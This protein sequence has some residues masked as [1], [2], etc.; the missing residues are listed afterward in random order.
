MMRIQNLISLLLAAFLVVP[1]RP[2]EALQVGR[3]NLSACEPVAGAPPH[4]FCGQLERPLDPANPTGEQ[5]SIHFEYYRHTAPGRSFGVMVAVEGGPGYPSTGTRDDYYVLY[6]PMRD[7]ND[8]LLMDSRGTGRSGA[9]RCEALQDA[10]TPTV[11]LV[12]ACG[13]QLGARAPLF[14]TSLAA[15]DLAAILD[16]LAL[17]RADLYADSYGTYFA[18]VFATRHGGKL[19]S[20]ILDGAYP[21]GGPD[22]AWYPNYAPAVRTRFNVACARSPAC[23]RLPGDSIGHIRPA[24]AL[25]RQHPHQVT[26]ID[27]DGQSHTFEANAARL[28]TLMFSGAPAYATLRETDA[29]ARAYASGDEAPLLRLMAESISATDSRDASN[30]PKNWSAGL[31]A[32]VMCLD[33]P[34]VFDLNLALPLRREQFRKVLAERARTQPLA[35]APFTQEEYL[36]LPLDYSFIEQCID[37]PAPPPAFPAPRVN[38][39]V[40][41]P[42][43]PA[44]VISGEF[45]TM[46][47]V[48]DAMAVAAHFRHSEHVILANSFHV[49]ALPHGRTDCAM[50]IAQRFLKTRQAGDTRCAQAVPPIALARDFARSVRTV[51]PAH[52]KAAGATDERALRCAAAAVLTAGDVL[53]RVRANGSGH[54]VGLRGGTF[55][56]SGPPQEQQVDLDAVRWTLDLSVS[57]QIQWRGDRAPVIAQLHWSESGPCG[58]GDLEVR[59][60]QDVADAQATVSGHIDAARVDAVLPAP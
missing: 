27:A 25:L 33:P 10:S 48:A 42:D 37:W 16:A 51:E 54:G 53:T 30:D 38:A 41:Y 3:L 34:Q 5:I 15:D 32:A 19:R 58:H 55:R 4:R 49:N 17:P 44:L 60:P 36:G 45:D 2:S 12:G 43:I 57:G 52:P 35:Y 18:Q 24:L 59:W 28:A 6:E 26:A 50:N 23:S 14:S 21:L 31:A 20:I 47:P 56:I 1:A 11:E 40:A 13:A 29:A 7:R 22:Y 46:T 39:D 8:L 9:I